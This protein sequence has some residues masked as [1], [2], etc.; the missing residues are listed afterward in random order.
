MRRE[1]LYGVAAIAIAVA[2]QSQPVAAADHVNWTGPYIGGHLGVGQSNWDGLWDPS[3]SPPVNFSDAL[4]ET[5]I[6]GGMHVGANYQV[7]SE[8]WASFVF[9]AEVDVSAVGGMADGDRIDTADQI[10]NCHPDESAQCGSRIDWVASLRGRLGV[11]FDQVLFFGTVGP[12]I[13]DAKA[14]VGSSS[15]GQNF[16]FEDLGIAWGLGVDWMAQ[17]HLVVGAEFLQYR[18]DDDQRIF[19]EAT[20]G[21]PFL[22]FDNVSVIRI[23]LS[24]KF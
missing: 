1:L 23:R 24:Y 20:S 14:F 6:I 7:P 3:G 13:A 9:G 5:G 4:G 18:F 12:A 10:G 8:R 21:D 22:E 16:D 11:A 15:S 19:F 17:P 2:Y